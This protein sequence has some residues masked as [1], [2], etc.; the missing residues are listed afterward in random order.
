V[1]ND[2]DPNSDTFVS[3]LRI[4]SSGKDILPD[5]VAGDPR[6]KNGVEQGTSGSKN[7]KRHTN[8]G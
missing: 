6:S 7:Q 2:V 8:A 3:E 1:C 4:T 5:L